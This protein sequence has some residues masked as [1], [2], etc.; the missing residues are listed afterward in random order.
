[1]AWGVFRDTESYVAGKVISPEEPRIELQ[2]LGRWGS[3]YE[4]C[5]NPDCCVRAELRSCVSS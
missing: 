3:W 4:R 5:K 2:N 1:M